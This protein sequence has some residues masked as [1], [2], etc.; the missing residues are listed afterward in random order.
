MCCTLDVRMQLARFAVMEPLDQ[1]TILSTI[2]LIPPTV[3]PADCSNAI[4]YAWNNAIKISSYIDVLLLSHGVLHNESIASC[5]WSLY[6]TFGR[7]GEGVVGRIYVFKKPFF[8]SLYVCLV[9]I[10]NNAFLV[11]LYATF[12][13]DRFPNQCCYQ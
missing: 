1:I 4:S 5:L 7:G 12:I 11:K 10:R 8:L 2:S 3:F 9:H 6:F 13:T